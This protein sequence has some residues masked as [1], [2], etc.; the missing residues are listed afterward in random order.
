MAD[1][2]KLEPVKLKEL[3]IERILWGDDK[4]QFTGKVEFDGPNGRILLVLPHDLSLKYLQVSAE[5]LSTISAQAAE[6]LKADVLASV[7]E[8]SALPAA[9][10]PLPIA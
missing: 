5:I 9:T 1:A 2:I 10:K 8:A 7:E 6:R 3:H 4:G